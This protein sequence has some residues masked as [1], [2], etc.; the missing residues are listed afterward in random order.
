MRKILLTLAFVLLSGIGVKAQ[1]YVHIVQK[2]STTS[3]NLNEVES[4]EFISGIWKPIG[5]A[6]YTEGLVS[7][8]FG[9]QNLTYEV[10]VE[11]D[12]LNSHLIRLVNPY[13]EAYP[14]NSPGDYSNVKHYMVFNLKDPEG[15]YM[16]GYHYSGMDWG[17]G[18]FVFGCL[19]YYY[20]EK[21]NS[22]EAVK[23]AGYMGTLDENLCITFPANTMLISMADYNGGGL[24]RSNKDGAFMVDLST[25]TIA[26]AK[27]RTKQTETQKKPKKE[28]EMTFKVA[29]NNFIA[30]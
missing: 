3:V 22:F 19:A 12:V 30:E 24:Y 4:L 11:Q 27:Q 25:T 23:A 14:Y 17:Y 20:M 6:L 9:V 16:D 10:E 1:N 7:T 18:E 29:E 5:K 28:G 8:V 15:V 21:G 13:G 26:K 2:D